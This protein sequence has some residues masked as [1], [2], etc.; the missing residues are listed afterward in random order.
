MDWEYRYEC[1]CVLCPDGTLDKN[2]CQ[3][4]IGCPLT[5]AGFNGFDYGDD[6]NHESYCRIGGC[7]H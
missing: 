1:G 3:W 4:G 5:L 6:D 2:G 7:E